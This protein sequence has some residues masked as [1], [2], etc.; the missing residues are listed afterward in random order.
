M[1]E[2]KR[3]HME[4]DEIIQICE[5]N[6]LDTAAQLFG[7]SIQHLGKFD[8]Y[9]GGANLVYQYKHGGQPR[10]L[11]ISCRPDWSVETIQVTLYIVNY[12]TKSGLRLATSILSR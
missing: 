12:L 10:V 1:D 8:D 3:N 4:R 7:T 11:C 6:V 9:E 2:T 5:Q